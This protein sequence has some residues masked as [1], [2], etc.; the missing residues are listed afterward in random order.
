M[1]EN[2]AQVP[3]PRIQPAKP[4]TRVAGGTR[5]SRQLW[6]HHLS[7]PESPSRTRLAS[8]PPGSDRLAPRRPRHRLSSAAGCETC[9][10]N[11]TPWTRYGHD[12]V[13]CARSIAW[14][15]ALTQM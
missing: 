8:V 14:T 4:A 2:R 5:Q 1:H 11:G 13:T 15:P 10:V 9:P 6:E 7:S 12:L 3:A